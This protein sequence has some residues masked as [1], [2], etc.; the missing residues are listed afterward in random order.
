M[1]PYKNVYPELEKWMLS[2]GVRPEELAQK[3]Y[4]T[5]LAMSNRLRGTTDFAPLE[6]EKLVKITGIPEEMLLCRKEEER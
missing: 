6:K 4:I 2:S 5:P 3:L 1:R